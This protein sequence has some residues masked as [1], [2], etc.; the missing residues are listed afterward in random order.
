MVGFTYFDLGWTHIYFLCKPYMLRTSELRYFSFFLTNSMFYLL[1]SQNLLFKIIWFL[2][3]FIFAITK[4]LKIKNLIQCTIFYFRYLQTQTLIIILFHAYNWFIKL[5]PIS[6]W[7][8][9]FRSGNPVIINEL[10][11][12]YVYTKG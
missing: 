12:W 7:T 2:P 9:S 8:M 6:L 5:M 4:Y 1:N 11:W 3:H 10:C